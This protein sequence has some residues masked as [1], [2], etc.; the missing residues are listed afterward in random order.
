M[1]QAVVVV[2]AGLTSGSL[3]TAKM[4]FEQNREVFAIPGRVDSPVSQG[5]NQLIGRLQAHLMTGYAD[6]LTEMN[7]VPAPMVD[8]ERRTMVELFG[9]EKEIFDLIEQEPIQFD[10][11]SQKLS[12]S[13]HE[14]SASLTML[15][16]AGIVTRLPGDW[17][18]RQKASFQAPKQKIL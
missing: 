10:L 2:E 16:L 8:G 4:A 14:L 17:Y 12:M 5:T 9:R 7:W 3:I 1:S 13:A 15:E 18:E 6:V 11:L